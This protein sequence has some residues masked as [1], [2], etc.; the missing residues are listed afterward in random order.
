[1]IAK[2]KYIYANK[3]WTTNKFLPNLKLFT[4]SHNKFS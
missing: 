3:P 2:Y 1:M 4:K